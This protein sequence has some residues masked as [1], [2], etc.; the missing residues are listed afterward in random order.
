MCTECYRAICSAA[1]PSYRPAAPHTV[2]AVCGEPLA[3]GEECYTNGRH[4]LCAGCADDLDIDTLLT[5]GHLSD[6]GELLGLL[7]FTHEA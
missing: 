2:C 1:C 7:G 5:L 4:H 6:T 3:P